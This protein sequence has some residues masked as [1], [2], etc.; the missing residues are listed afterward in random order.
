[1]YSGYSK[2]PELYPT[3]E[4]M[5]ITRWLLS[6]GKLVERDFNYDR[7]T[8]EL[9]IDLLNDKLTVDEF[10]AEMQENADLMIGE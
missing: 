8:E 9:V 5:Q 3:E 10:V 7:R 1:M 4:E 2:F 6:Q